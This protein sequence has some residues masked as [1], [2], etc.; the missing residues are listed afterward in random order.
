[1]PNIL[2]HLLDVGNAVETHE[3]KHSRCSL[4]DGGRARTK[5]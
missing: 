5:H 4:I 2:F 1:M 3:A